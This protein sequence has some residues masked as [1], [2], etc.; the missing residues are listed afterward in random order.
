GDEGRVV[1]T[2]GAVP[3]ELGV[4]GVGLGAVQVRARGLEGG[5]GRNRVGFRRLHG[6][7]IEID[8]GQRLHVLKLRQQLSLLY[9]VAFLDVQLDDPAHGIGSDVRVG[10]G[11][12]FT[13]GADHRSQVL[14]LRFSG[15]YRHQV[16]LAFVNGDGD[17]D[18]ESQRRANS[19]QH[20]L[21]GLHDEVFLTILPSQPP[22]RRTALKFPA[23][24][25]WVLVWNGENAPQLRM[26][27]YVQTSRKVPDFQHRPGYGGGDL[28]RNS[29]YRAAHRR[30]GSG[31]GPTKRS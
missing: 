14:F 11:L 12:D 27:S 23:R 8:V 2:L 30:C 3:I 1:Q 24:P 7:A 17:D 10:L 22:R 19:D 20:F 13:R 4:D 25:P 15:L 21:P 5:I 18:A 31:A 6:R 29:L 28:R 26:N 16:L 9:A